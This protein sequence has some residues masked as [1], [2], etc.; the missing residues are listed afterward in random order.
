MS[1]Y[2]TFI[3]AVA[4]LGLATTVFAAD[5]NQDAAA[6]QNTTEIAAMSTN[7]SDVTAST[8]QKM[9]DINMQTEYFLF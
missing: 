8:E 9:V 2:R 4:T 3:A 6:K 1:F 5:E 7:S